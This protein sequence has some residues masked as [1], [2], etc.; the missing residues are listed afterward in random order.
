MPVQCNEIL[1]KISMRVGAGGR[2][3][4]LTIVSKFGAGGGGFSLVEL[5][6]T[7]NI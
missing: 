3:A 2:L 1:E 6:A 4:G 5:H 7:K